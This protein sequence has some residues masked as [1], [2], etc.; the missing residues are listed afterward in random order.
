GAI[1]RE[2]GPIDATAF[3]TARRFVMTCTTFD[4]GCQEFSGFGTWGV[5]GDLVLAWRT[6]SVRPF[7][8]ISAAHVVANAPQIGNETRTAIALGAAWR[9]DRMGE[10]ALLASMRSGHVPGWNRTLDAPATWGFVIA[11]AP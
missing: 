2:I 8:S 6:E 1:T 10:L 7:A 4:S 5:D 11:W 9:R 3:V